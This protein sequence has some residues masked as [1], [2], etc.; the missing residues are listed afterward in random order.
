MDDVPPY[1]DLLDFLDL[2]AQASESLASSTKRNSV[3]PPG[4]RA[5]QSGNVALFTVAG[6]NYSS[7]C[8]VCTTERHHCI[9]VL[10]SS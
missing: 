5:T 9:C 6:S 7:N 1:Q 4:K 3:Q 8:V 10:S 2:R